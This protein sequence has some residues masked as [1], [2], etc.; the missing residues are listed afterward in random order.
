MFDVVDG[1]SRKR[2]ARH[3]VKTFAS[4]SLVIAT[5]QAGA[6]VRTTATATAATTAT[7]A[8]WIRLV[9]IIFSKTLRIY[10]LLEVGLIIR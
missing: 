9:D 3:M 2:I 4:L 8:L 6:I 7:L 5:L 10:S 1:G